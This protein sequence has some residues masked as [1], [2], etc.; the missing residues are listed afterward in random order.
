[1]ASMPKSA[2]E[3]GMSTKE[4]GELGR[5]VSRMLAISLYNRKIILSRF[6][7]IIPEEI[8]WELRPKINKLKED[9][10]YENAFYEFANIPYHLGPPEGQK[11]FS[12]AIIDFLLR[13]QSLL[14]SQ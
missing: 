11:L 12:T 3:F 4:Y 14:E 8:R 2:Q 7:K 5:N 6:D 1:M 9:I 10:Q 13:H